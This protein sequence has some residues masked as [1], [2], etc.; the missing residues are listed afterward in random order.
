MDS[1]DKLTDDEMKRLEAATCAD[2]WNSACD[3]VK[4]ARGRQYPY[5]W[6]DRVIR[7]GLMA[8]ISQDWE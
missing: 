2:E 3:A 1:N 6:F 4:A 7:S 8:R 5:D